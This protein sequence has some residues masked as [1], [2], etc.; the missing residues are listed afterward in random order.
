MKFFKSNEDR[1]LWIKLNAQH[2]IEWEKSLTYFDRVSQTYK[3]TQQALHPRTYNDALEVA[4]NQLEYD[5]KNKDAPRYTLEEYL[6]LNLKE[7]EAIRL[8]DFQENWAPKLGPL[9]GPFK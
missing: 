5:E 6:T 7:L 2:Q 4:R 1:E 8:K 3:P 9:K